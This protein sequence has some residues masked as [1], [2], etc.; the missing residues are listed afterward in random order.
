MSGTTVEILHIL[1]GLA[2]AVAMTWAAAWSYPLA[3]GVIWWCG[4][5]AMVA[6]VAMGIRPL[7]HAR[8]RELQTRGGNLETKA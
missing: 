6:T 1:A 8:R 3:W 7:R 2:A 5:A 4:A